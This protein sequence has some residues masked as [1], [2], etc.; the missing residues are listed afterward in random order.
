MR[1]ASKHETLGNSRIVE[2]Q[3]RVT[4]YD[5]AIVFSSGNSFIVIT[6]VFGAPADWELTTE[7][8]RLV[9]ASCHKRKAAPAHLWETVAQLNPQAFVWAG[10]TVYPPK[11]GVASLELLKHEYEQLRYNESLGY[12]KFIT[13]N[14]TVEVVGTWDDH[15]Y[16][17]NDAGKELTQREERR[18]LFLDML[19]YSPEKQKRVFQNRSG[20]YHSVDYINPN[21]GTL[22]VILLDTRWNRD[23]HC[24]P[25]LAGHI[26]FGFGTIFACL[27]RWLTAGLKMT[28]CTRNSTILGEEQWSWLKLQLDGN[29]DLSVVV[30][31]I[32]FFTTNPVMEGWGHFPQEQQRLLR[33]LNGKPT[34]ILSGDVH[35]AEL[36]SAGNRQQVLEVT[37][38][39]ITHSCQQPWY[40]K[41]ACEP[42]LQT[43]HAHRLYRDA[44]FLKPN[45][46]F[47]EIDWVKKH[48]RVGIHSTTENVSEGTS[49]NAVLSTGW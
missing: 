43:F 10:D 1:K 19:G 30:S 7:V 24:W 34:I 17:A 27:T 45:L 44:Y 32:Q 18:R 22:R 20:V 15:D 38:S 41:Y 33:L 39:G 4:D 49:R 28:G 46:G 26:P 48:F 40:G 16:G 9:F 37:S 29:A 25:S 47:L 31:S 35:Y 36:S 8:S 11:R 12:R 42:L 23:F 2:V 14:P 5:N 13:S 21:G 3:R 6:L